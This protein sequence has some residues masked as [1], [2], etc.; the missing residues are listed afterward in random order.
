MVKTI[1]KKYLEESGKDE[2][3]TQCGEMYN[4]IQNYIDFKFRR[5]YQLIYSSQLKQHFVVLINDDE[6]ED[7]VYTARYFYDEIILKDDDYFQEIFEE[8]FDEL[9]KSMIQDNLITLNFEYQEV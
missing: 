5:N 1:I 2:N 9:L 4:V 7:N 6:E 3:Q 8:N